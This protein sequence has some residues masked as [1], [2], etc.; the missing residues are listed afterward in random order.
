MKKCPFCAEAIQDEATKCRYCGEKL[1][2]S[3][4]PATAS[5][6]QR[7]QMSP[8]AGGVKRKS[9]LALA[10]GRRGM[11]SGLVILLGV[12]M[13]ISTD[14]GVVGAGQLLILGG[15]IGVLTGSV[16]A[17][18]AVGLLAMILVGILGVAINPQRLQTPAATSTPP[19]PVQ[20]QKPVPEPAEWEAIPSFSTSPE[21]NV[22]SLVAGVTWDD[23]LP[24]LNVGTR[25]D[26][27]RLG[28]DAFTTT[29]RFPDGGGCLSKVVS[30][31]FRR[32]SEPD[33]GPYKIVRIACK[34]R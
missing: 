25:L 12:G 9:A 1:P 22:A 20:E 23:A 26:L 10:R 4:P 19:P 34:L 27:Q 6:Q 13:N 5:P 21:F 3:G 29:Y 8:L 2:S 14:S 16:V 33:A 11:W 15:A 32:P 30:I 31:T 28:S 24:A 17:R 7:Q 18:V